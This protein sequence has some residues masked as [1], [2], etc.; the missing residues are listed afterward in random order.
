MDYQY[1]Y[2][3]YK[4]KYNR[5]YQ[6]IYQFAGQLSEPTTD[7]KDDNLAISEA[8]NKF[9]INMIDNFDR[10]S[11]IFSPTSITFALSLIHLG[12]LGKTDSQLSA[13]LCHKYSLD[14]LKYVDDLFNNNIIKMNTILVLN[15]INKV[16]P[17]YLNMVEPIATIAYENM[18]DFALVAN[19]I[20]HSIEKNTDG[21][22]KEVLTTGDIDLNTIMIIV[23]T[24]Y[25]KALWQ[26]KFDSNF[27]TKMKFHKTESDPI[28]MMHQIN[29]FNYYENSAVQMV[30]LPYADKNYVMGIILPKKYIEEENI[31]YS[32]NNVP[33]LSEQ[34]INEMINNTSY[35][36]I[37]LYIP[38]FTHKKRY[39]L[40][41]ILKKMGVIDV[42]S[43]KYAELDVISKN[44][45]ISKII[46]EAVV[47]VDESGTI[48]SA[49]TAIVV[50][51]R[52]A[53]L[54]VDKPIL[55]QANHAFIYY[56]RHIDTNTFLF[57]GDYQGN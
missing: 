43:E 7:S 46:H 14:E 55:F 17:E 19:K 15:R 4:R 51:E 47:I 5:L 11:N 1:K 25:F 56:I 52:S 2:Q 41:P 38:K 53:N 28:D 33:I 16:N 44:I 35:K 8:N 49:T 36:K 27:T 32:I 26:N 40:V 42:F 37:D 30:E 6:A 54:S 9:T 34:E 18:D 23:N 57:Y 12:A 48:A 50:N 24:I 20:N 3:K 31:D 10:A 45:Y 39:S 13:V 21:H 22:I 29:D